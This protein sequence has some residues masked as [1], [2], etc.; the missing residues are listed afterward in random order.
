M[1]EVLEGEL[2]DTRAVVATPQLHELAGRINQ[3]DRQAVSALT[4][5]LDWAIQVGAA[6][7]EAKALV[8]HG[9]WLTWLA[10]NC[11][12][13]ADRTAR[14]YM[15]VYEGTRD[16]KLDQIGT[17]AN[18]DMTHVVAALS[19]PRAGL[20]AGTRD[21][22][23]TVLDATA[24]EPRAYDEGATLMQ[25]ALRA[26]VAVEQSHAFGRFRR[27]HNQT[28]ALVAAMTVTEDDSEWHLNIRALGEFRFTTEKALEKAQK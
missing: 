24:D 28:S 7:T 12:T 20:G 17:R 5:G 22:A 26:I 19:T 13:I 3:L 1:S 10:E 9:H 25:E 18:L 2:L 27:Q 6:L 15:Q 14:K 16:G 23:H 4:E 21:T 11:P 8:G